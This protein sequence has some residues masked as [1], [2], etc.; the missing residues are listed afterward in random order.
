[1]FVVSLTESR[2]SEFHWKTYADGDTGFR[3]DFKTNLLKWNEV[4]DKSNLILIRVTYDEEA[5]VKLIDDV[6]EF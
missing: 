4:M 2:E 5:Q 1:M 6:L 3:L